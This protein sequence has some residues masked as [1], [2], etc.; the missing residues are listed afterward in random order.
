[1]STT[2]EDTMSEPRTEAL[3]RLVTS[4]FGLQTSRIQC[5]RVSALE[6]SRLWGY[7]GNSSPSHV[8]KKGT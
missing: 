4:C 1:M 8:H 6:A 5:F 3:L 7:I 2:E